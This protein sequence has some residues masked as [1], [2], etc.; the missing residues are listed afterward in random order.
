V[1][2][3]ALFVSIDIVKFWTWSF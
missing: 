1:A 2:F 3:I